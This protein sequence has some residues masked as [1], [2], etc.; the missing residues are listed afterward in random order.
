MILIGR[1]TGQASKHPRPVER[2]VGDHQTPLFV[3][4]CVCVRKS[5]PRE[6]A[7]GG[8]HNMGTPPEVNMPLA[9]RIAI[10]G[11]STFG[12]GADVRQLR[13]Q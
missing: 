1:F 5:T 4:T 6:K 7:R 10:G 13:R 2:E 9:I 12:V 3:H 8:N 11:T